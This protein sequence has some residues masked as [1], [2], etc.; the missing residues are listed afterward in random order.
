VVPQAAIPATN[1][2]ERF[3][4]LTRSLPF[5]VWTATPEGAI[6]YFNDALVEYTRRDP[7]EL[8]ADG[9]LSILHPEDVPVALAQQH[10]TIETGD[11]Y[12]LKIRLLRWDGEYRWHNVRSAPEFDDDGTLL[13]RWGSAVDIHE[14]RM[15]EAQAAKLAADREAILESIGDGVCTLDR[16]FCFTYLNSHVLALLPLPREEILGKVVWDVIPDIHDA[17]SV[18]M[19]QRVLKTG[20]PERKQYYSDSLKAWF[21]VS[22]NPF[23][24]GL[25]LH[26]RD[27][28]QVKSL[29]E[30]L[31]IA[32][33]L[34]AI[35]QLTGGIAHDFNN[36]LTV[37]MG[38]MDS[39][40]MENHLSPAGLE[41]IDLVSQAT[42]RGVELTHRLLAFARQQPLAPQ[43]IDVGQHVTDL[44][45]ILRRTLGDEIEVAT[46]LAPGLPAAHV[47]PGQFESALLNLGINARD[48]MPDGGLL[49]L[50]TGM[51]ELDEEYAANHGDV[52]P[53]KYIIVSVG[54]TGTGIAPEHMER[55]FD[56]FFTTKPIG[57]G[58]GL[59][60]PMVWGFVKQS[61]GHLSVYS[62]LGRGTTIRLYLP[63]SSEDAEKKE[64]EDPLAVPATM[65]GSGHV[66]LV[67]DD[68]FVRRFA[69]EQLTDHGYKVTA[70]GSG[71]EA[72]E[73]LDSIKHID[74]LFTDVIL[75]GGMTGRQ[76]A[77][78][79]VARRPGTPV[80]YASGYTESVLMHDGRL[81]PDV[82]LLPK[83]YTN[84]Q[85][86][87][88][89]HELISAPNAES[90]RP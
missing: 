32:H 11:P 39:L 59:G 63:V 20:Q 79:V 8:L 56:P 73:I 61:G 24:D 44:L 67:E 70:T 14:V 30:Q 17:D 62:E 75:P 18:A 78:E 21:D 27:I 41:M 25:T 52:K 38:A 43:A 80:L 66:L 69:T 19:F 31:A 68:E 45:H 64:E 34:D 87:G 77:I 60:L 36:F 54:D 35:G 33:R 72:L 3:N 16:D 48:A 76:L 40:T 51:T 86:L 47:D 42:A 55:L 58:S 53:G 26:V 2:H 89:V 57:Q 65:R 9:W 23:S 88:R 71:P 82:S 12:E 49:E 4:Q 13:R 7:K 6:D 84:R 5:V 29:S 37:V 85:L 1:P 46:A 28:T 81:D 90:A 50:E 22:V 83:P 10:H 74:L 15:L